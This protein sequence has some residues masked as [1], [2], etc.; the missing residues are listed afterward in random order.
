MSDGDALSALA[1][2]TPRPK[3]T[4]LTVEIHND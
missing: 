1:D 2:V 4:R 3:R